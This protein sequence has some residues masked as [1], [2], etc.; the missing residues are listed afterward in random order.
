[1]QEKRQN[2]Q[3]YFC[4]EP[5][6][7]DH[8]CAAKGVFLMELE[9]GEE[10][11]LGADITNL[12]I[13]LYALIGLGHANSMMLQV[14][15][16]GVPLKALVDTGST[17]TFIH[18]EVVDRLGLPV[19]SRDRLSV[20]L[21]N[22]DCVRIPSVCL[23]A[24]VLIHG[25]PFSID[26]VALDLGGFDLVLGIQWPRT[27]GLRHP[28]DGLLVPGPCSQLDR[29]GQQ[30]SGCPCYRQFPRHIGGAAAVLCGHLRGAARAA[31]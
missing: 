25:E 9:A 31:S 24:D 27:L 6:S 3:C 5:Y 14:T 12:E 8:K 29:P 1:M 23:A 13:S 16:A 20:L 22:G 7:K 17:H 2:G 10:D 4:P 19:S 26:C 11:P 18:T 15:I 21:A 30:G 28:F